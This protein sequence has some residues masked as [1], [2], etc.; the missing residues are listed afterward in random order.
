MIVAANGVALAFDGLHPP[1]QPPHC[2]VGHPFD[3][4]PRT[5]FPLNDP[6]FYYDDQYGLFVGIG[7]ND[8][9]HEGIVIS[10]PDSQEWGGDFASVA[11]TFLVGTPG[12]CPAG[13]VCSDQPKLGLGDTAV[14][15]ATNTQSTQ[16]MLY[17]DKA[18]FMAGALNCS[19]V[20]ADHP[21][22]IL[23]WVPAHA[24]GGT[25]NAVYAARF[26]NDLC[27]IIVGRGTGPW[28]APTWVTKQFTLANCLRF[29][30]INQPDGTILTYGLIE[31]SD[32]TYNAGTIW[33]M[34]QDQCGAWGCE[35][36]LHFYNG[37]PN[38]SNLTMSNVCT[39]TDGNNNLFDG[40]M[41]FDDV[42]AI[43]GV[44][45]T[46]GPSSYLSTDGWGFE[47]DNGACVL[48]RI[49][50][51]TA[52]LP[53]EPGTVTQRAGDFSMTA[54]DPNGDWVWSLGAAALPEQGSV[55]DESVLTQVCRQPV[56]TVNG[57]FC[58]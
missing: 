40:S 43:G 25:G 19:Q 54:Q 49:A 4:G 34:A 57:G 20:G 26:T 33:L 23:T 12:S 24:L 10:L 2:G 16:A 14:L 38:W 42:A 58:K 51:G 44:M 53:A 45:L 31:P 3:W 36:L 7:V 9:T 8:D 17:C 30:L 6:R 56:Y 5:P 55:F 29:P 39:F 47:T 52:N 18:S 1:C 48:Q 37:Q 35:R 27:G 32:V 21:D 41:A 28:N 11:N 15:L 46:V 50:N 22:K 13:S